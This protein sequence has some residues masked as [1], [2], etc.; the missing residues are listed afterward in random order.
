MKI[1]STIKIYRNELVIYYKHQNETLRL[2]LGI[3]LSKK[4][5]NS[6]KE[7]IEK[8]YNQL[9]EVKKKKLEIDELIIQAIEA[10]EVNRVLYVKSNLKENGEYV[11]KN[12]STQK[13]IQN[14]NLTS[15]YSEFLNEYYLSKNRLKDG[16]K[17]VWKTGLTDITNFVNSQN[18]YKNLAD[19]D[20]DFINAFQDYLLECTDIIDEEKVIKYTGR[21]IS[22]KTQCM[23]KFIRTNKRNLSFI[24]SNDDN[25]KVTIYAS[26]VITFTDEEYQQILNYEAE[27]VKEQKIKDMTIVMCS[28][29]LNISDMKQIDDSFINDKNILDLNRKKSGT[30][31]LLPLNS[32]TLEILKRYNYNMNLVSDPIYNR[33]VKKMLKKIPIF[34]KK[35]GY[36][37]THNAETKSKPKYQLIS[38]RTCRKYF[39][40]YCIKQGMP[41][42]QITLL[43]G[44]SDIKQ[45]KY[46]M[47][48][49][50]DVQLVS[51]ILEKL[52]SIT[53]VV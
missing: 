46:Y 39:I 3:Q 17:K 27:N 53:K 43:V 16:T 28:T 26:D 18:K 23:K 20:S 22:K 44:H 25:K 24:Y 7:V 35:C 1:E 29:S 8:K 14:D 31:Q 4:E 12:C 33:E 48:K 19:V 21:T 47:S 45:I 6:S 50:Q 11:F 9:T 32:I 49:M 13:P 5:I 40:T 38:S 37:D 42:D 52:S 41:L 51:P 10:H 15:L 2:P 34:L 36:T 30:K